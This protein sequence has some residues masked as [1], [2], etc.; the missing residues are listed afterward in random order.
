MSA[1]ERLA[2]VLK[3][4]VLTQIMHGMDER[5]ST[6]TVTA[7]RYDER[8]RVADELRL[9]IHIPP[10]LSVTHLTTVRQG[11]AMG[12]EYEKDAGKTAFYAALERMFG[13]AP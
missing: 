2:S 5:G 1:S 13:K 4:G 9:T 6:C 8:G 3:H 11:A 10:E 7:V 12:G